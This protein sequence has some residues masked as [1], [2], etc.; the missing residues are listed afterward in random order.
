ML[1][2]NYYVDFAMV[3]GAE[4]QAVFGRCSNSELG[5][6]GVTGFGWSSAQ[7]YV[8]PVSLNPLN[9]KHKT[10]PKP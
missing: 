6:F 9:A 1:A 5:Q 8:N 3:T 2:F 10:N 4:L 7:A